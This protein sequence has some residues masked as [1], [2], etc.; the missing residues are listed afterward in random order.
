MPTVPSVPQ[1]GQ[2]WHRG[3]HDMS[4]Q[5]HSWWRVLHLTLLPWLRKVWLSTAAQQ[6]GG[7]VLCEKKNWV[8]KS[9]R[10]EL[11][12]F[13][14]SEIGFKGHWVRCLSFTDTQEDCDKFAVTELEQGPWA[15]GRVN[16]S[17]HGCHNLSLKANYLPN[18]PKS[19]FCLAR[20]S[21]PW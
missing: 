12:D 1:R 13:L 17:L 21:I 5:S 6:S 15:P 11:Q 18:N 8:G 3:G 20:G 14:R 16:R 10:Q 19:Q 4:G 9:L 7:K 2:E